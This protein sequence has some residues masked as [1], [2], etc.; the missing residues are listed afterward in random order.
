MDV[1]SSNHPKVTKYQDTEANAHT[2]VPEDVPEYHEVT[3]V[4]YRD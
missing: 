4:E 1:D 2:E 3:V